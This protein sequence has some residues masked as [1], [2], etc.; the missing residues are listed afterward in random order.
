MA[1][2]TTEVYGFMGTGKTLKAAREDAQDQ[3][4][5]A[6]AGSYVPYVIQHRGMLAV[7]HRSPTGWSYRI[8]EIKADGVEIDVQ[9]CSIF[10][11]GE[12][13]KTV[14]HSMLRHLAQIT[15]RL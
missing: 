11:R 4:R 7:A 1:T 10:P 15:M 14:V 13:R 5:I 6:M 8:A 12:D 2:I 3:A 9:G